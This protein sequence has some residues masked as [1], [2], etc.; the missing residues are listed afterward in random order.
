MQPH[1]AWEI[2]KDDVLL[3]R[4]HREATDH[5]EASHGALEPQ[6]GRQELVQ[7]TAEA[8]EF[9][10]AAG[11]FACFARGQ[12]LWCVPAD[13]SWTPTRVTETGTWVTGL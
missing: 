11:K 7:L 10:G 9:A 12:A 1:E 6:G 5:S 8:D 4:E 3:C 2:V 13:G